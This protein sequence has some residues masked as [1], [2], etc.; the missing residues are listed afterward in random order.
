[1]FQQRDLCQEIA[2]KRTV[3]RLIGSMVARKF[4]RQRFSPSSSVN[5]PL[6]VTG[7]NGQ[8]NKPIVPVVPV[9]PLLGDGASAT[10]GSVPSLTRRRYRVL[11]Y[12][13]S[14]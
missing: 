13:L 8:G 7:D 2:V 3:E 6:I 11:S 9:P 14:L 12:A 4:G 1:V 5:H 10:D